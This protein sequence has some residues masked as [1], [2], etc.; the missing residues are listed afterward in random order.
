MF[1]DIGIFEI[2]L[3][4]VILLVLFGGNKLPEIGKSLGQAVKEFKNALGGKDKK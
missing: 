2:V 3:I 4:A 1:R